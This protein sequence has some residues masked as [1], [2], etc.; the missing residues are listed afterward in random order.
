MGCEATLSSLKESK[1]SIISAAVP[2]T[3]A[4]R[5]YGYTRMV[6]KRTH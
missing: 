5:K 1:N 6:F 3:I 4:L 2:K